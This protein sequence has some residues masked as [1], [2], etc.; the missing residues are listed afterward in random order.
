MRDFTEVQIGFLRIQ[1]RPRIKP[2]GGEYDYEIEVEPGLYPV[3]ASP[4]VGSR[5]IGHSLKTIVLG[6]VTDPGLTSFAH[7]GSVKN[8]EMEV[9]GAQLFALYEDGRFFPDYTVLTFSDWQKR[10]G[11]EL[12]EPATSNRGRYR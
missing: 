12:K 9:L 1:D 6:L 10:Q 5:E 11:F 3:I 8:G 2:L 7:L 4:R